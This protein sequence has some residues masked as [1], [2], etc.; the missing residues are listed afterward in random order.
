MS[1]PPP[2]RGSDPQQ[3]ATGRAETRRFAAPVPPE[4]PV[5]AEPATPTGTPAQ[6]STRRRSALR[7]GAAAA[8]LLGVG[9]VVG[10]IVG[11]VTADSASAGTTSSTSRTAPDG[12]G[13]GQQYGTPP[14]GRRGGM[15]PGLG[16]EVPGSTTDGTSDS[17]D[18]IT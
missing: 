3:P 14:D 6:A 16:P 11:Q 5:A 17:G 4:Q 15:P 8:G 1:E 12:T 7:T 9:V 13:G 2:P 18:P 10:V